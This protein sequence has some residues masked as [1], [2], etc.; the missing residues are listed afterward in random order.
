MKAKR[1]NP[2]AAQEWGDALERREAQIPAKRNFQRAALASRRASGNGLVIASYL[3]VHRDGRLIQLHLPGVAPEEAPTRGECEGISEDSRRRLLKMLHSLRRDA[4][5]P[6]MVTLTFP[7]ELTVTP[8]QAKACRKAWEKRMR[9]MHGKKWCH[10]WRLE[11]HPEMSARLG[12]VHPHFHLLT[13][14]AFYDFQRVSEYWNEC[15]WKVLKVADC[16]CD[17]EGRSVKEKHVAAGTNCERVRKWEGVIYCAKSYIAKEEE[18]PLGKA[19]RV[20]GW[21]NRAA[22]PMAE[23][24]RIPLTNSEASLVRMEVEAWMAERRIVSEHL[25][26]TFFDNDPSMFVARLMRRVTPQ[27]QP[28]NPQLPTRPK[29]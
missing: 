10:L 27:I 15:V 4:H 5:L 17:K 28:L 24:I 20:W 18:Y 25:V 3:A 23:E 1:T 29:K 16:L 6:V 21:H 13:W 19:G 11:A 22:L 2:N 8:E 14:G 26:C 7:E 12:R 9:R